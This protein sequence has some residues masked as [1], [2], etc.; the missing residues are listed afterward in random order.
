MNKIWR[1]L[2]WF[3]L[4]AAMPLAHA[5]I[6]EERLPLSFEVE[7]MPYAIGS[8]AHTDRWAYFVTRGVSLLPL[9]DKQEVSR[10]LHWQQDDD[11]KRVNLNTRGNYV[12]LIRRVPEPFAR[13]THVRW[14]WQVLKDTP[15]GR[16]GERPDDQAIQV[17]LI[18]R[19]QEPLEYKALSFAWTKDGR[20]ESA[21]YSTRLPQDNF[22]R[23]QVAVRRLRNGAQPAQ[24]ENVDIQAAYQEAMTTH[25]ARFDETP[26]ERPDLFGVVLFG[27]SSNQRPP[28]DA[29]SM[30]T[31][32]TITDLELVDESATPDSRPLFLSGSTAQ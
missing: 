17:I 13:A 10:Y 22:P 30:S 23:V 2:G 1:I 11:T 28:V 15:Q 27:E 31:E 6:A 7:P 16:L 24:A 20:R 4:L 14:N 12:A 32:A 18:F 26:G 3:G 19:R 9:T 8:E 21:V 25:G 5:A 29:H